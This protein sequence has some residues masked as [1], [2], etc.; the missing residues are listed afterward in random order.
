MMFAK[1]DHWIEQAHI[2]GFLDP[3]HALIELSFSRTPKEL[4]RVFRVSEDEMYFALEA[5]SLKPM[6]VSTQQRKQTPWE[7]IRDAYVQCKSLQKT[8]QIVGISRTVLRKILRKH[9]VHLQPQGGANNPK[10]RTDQQILWRGEL[11][12]VAALARQHGHYPG[13]VYKRLK[14]GLS[15]EEALS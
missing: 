1:M 12:T 5:L 13:T 3:R 9:G 7:H 15:L 14:R 6:N 2:L 10:G 11:T 4:S 8:S